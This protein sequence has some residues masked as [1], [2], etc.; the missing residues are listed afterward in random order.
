MGPFSGSIL[1]GMNFHAPYIV[2]GI[3]TIAGAIIILIAMVIIVRERRREIGVI[4]A[5][6]GS[7]GKVIAQFI[8][9]SLTLTIIGAIVGLALGIVVSGPMTNSLVTSSAQSS[10]NSPTGNPREMMRTGIN[11]INSS[12][13]TVT[14]SLTPQAFISAIGVTLLITIIGSAGPAWFIARIRPAEILRNE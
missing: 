11:R 8:T 1:Y 10:Q 7:N 5:I 13:N 3:L 4:K 2:A 9:E 14:A 12:L 6:G